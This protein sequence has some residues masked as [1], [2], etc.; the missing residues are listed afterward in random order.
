MYRDSDG[1]WKPVDAEGKFG[2]AMDKFNAVEFAPVE[3]NG[4]RLEVKLQ[5]EFSG[6][7]LEWRV[8]GLGEQAM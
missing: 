6:G 2:V 7:I 1:N 8:V 4:L 5:D 3:T